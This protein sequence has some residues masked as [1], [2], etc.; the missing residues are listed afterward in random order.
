M[1]ML[2]LL[3]GCLDVVILA[4]KSEFRIGRVEF[5][6]LDGYGIVAWKL[7]EIPRGNY[8][9]GAGP[10]QFPSGRAPNSLEKARRPRALDISA[11]KRT[12]PRRVCY[13]CD[14]ARK[15]LWRLVDVGAVCPCAW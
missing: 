12:Q 14:G 5:R 1:F 8:V 4:C 6:C 7:T 9:H 3:R 2:T 11:P 15:V 13:S 10:F